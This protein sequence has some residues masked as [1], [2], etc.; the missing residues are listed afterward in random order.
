[1]TEEEKK[2]RE[3]LTK[4][5]VDAFRDSLIEECARVALGRP[6]PDGRAIAAAIRAL[7]DKS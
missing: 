6:G 2:L 1:M 7:K 4:D 3:L 5:S